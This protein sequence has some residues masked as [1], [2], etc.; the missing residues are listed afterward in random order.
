M[1][2]TAREWKEE[3]EEEMKRRHAAKRLLQE[4]VAAK[5]DVVE[6]GAIDIYSG[7]RLFNQYNTLATMKE[8][9]FHRDVYIQCGLVPLYVER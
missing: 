9:V 8:L 2:M 4:K 3:I 7:H 6:I 5:Y 1:K